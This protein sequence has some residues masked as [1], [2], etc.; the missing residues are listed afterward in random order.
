MIK[1]H[2]MNLQLF[3]D[4]G[5][6]GDTNP[7]EEDVKKDEADVK[8]EK[9]KKV[10][11]PEKKYTD[12]DINK[13]IDSKFA[14]WQEQKDEE[15]DEAKK[16]A[17]M[18]AQEKAEFERDK[19]EK[20]LNELRQAQTKNQMTSTARS[21]LKEKEISIED[22]LLKLLVDTDA[23]KTK[24]NVDSFSTMFEKAVEK[25]V[26]ARIKNPNHKRGTTSTITKDEIMKIKDT[27][28]RQQKI[29]ENIHLFE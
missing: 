1:K 16:L 12:E 5:E 7:D 26:L 27:N 21:I 10:D 9:D 23:E 20:E 13:I 11:E 24:E 8:D 19:L 3:A 28:L 18:D 25:E 2:K 6:D 29:K 14:K 17:D 4:G 15:I 22:D